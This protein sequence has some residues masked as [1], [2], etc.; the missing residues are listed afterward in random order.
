MMEGY[1]SLPFTLPDEKHTFLF[2]S[3][4]KKAAKVD[5][6]KG[7]NKIVHHMALYFPLRSV[8]SHSC[9]VTD[10]LKPRGESVIQAHFRF[11]DK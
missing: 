4:T 5:L 1:H 11:T 8:G 10:V 2:I 3:V 6:Y 7:I 9:E